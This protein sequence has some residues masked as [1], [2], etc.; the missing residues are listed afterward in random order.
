MGEGGG[1]KIVCLGQFSR[2][3]WGDRVVKI[4]A[5]SFMKGPLENSEIIIEGVAV[6][7]RRHFF[8]AF[9]EGAALQ[10]KKNSGLGR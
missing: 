3:K 8:R 4:W 10:S 9:V 1:P 7:S 2:H 5:T 6:Q